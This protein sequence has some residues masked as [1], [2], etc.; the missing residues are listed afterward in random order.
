MSAAGHCG[1]YVEMA[2]LVSRRQIK[3]LVLK[4]VGSNPT[5]DIQ[6][7]PF[8]TSSA[9]VWRGPPGGPLPHKCKSGIL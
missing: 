7:P 1:F 5:L 4:G 3:V 9:G 2:E 8:C 6:L